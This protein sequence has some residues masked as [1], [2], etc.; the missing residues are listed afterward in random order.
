MQCLSPSIHSYLTS[1]LRPKVALLPPRN[2]ESARKMDTKNVPCKKR[3]RVAPGRRLAEPT[4]VGGPSPPLGFRQKSLPVRKSA[5]NLH[6][7]RYAL[8][9]SAREKRT[10]RTASRE[11]VGAFRNC[12]SFL[13]TIIL[14]SFRCCLQL[15]YGAPYQTRKGPAI[16]SHCAAPYASRIQ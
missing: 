2:V 4:S 14:T 7:S 15:L 9:K 8:Q 11:S 3:E 5:T 1:V 12:R 10:T 6:A 13:F 16:R